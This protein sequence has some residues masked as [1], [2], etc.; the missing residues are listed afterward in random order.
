MIKHLLTD[1]ELFNTALNTPNK[2]WILFKHSNSCSISAVGYNRIQPLLSDVSLKKI[3]FFLLDVIQFRALSR[4]IANL[5]GIPHE[6]P[7][8]ILFQNGK[9]LEVWN[10]F[11]INKNTLLNTLNESV[12]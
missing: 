5:V 2:T 7:Q 4:E 9:P 3:D 10:H 8:M 6:S 12:S 1:V 11:E